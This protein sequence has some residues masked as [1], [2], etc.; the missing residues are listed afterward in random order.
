MRRLSKAHAIRDIWG[1]CESRANSKNQRL[2]KN[3]TGK[4][5]QGRVRNII[6]VATVIKKGEL[7]ARY[8]AWTTSVERRDAYLVIGFYELKTMH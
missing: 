8:R 6:Q 4:L 1:A 5:Y 3:W 7:R 2:F